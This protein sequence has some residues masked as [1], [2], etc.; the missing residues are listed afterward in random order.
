MVTSARIYGEPE[1][2][3]E[4]S[5]A[6]PSTQASFTAVNIQR[7]KCGFLSGSWFESVPELSLWQQQGRSSSGGEPCGR[8]RWWWGVAAIIG[9]GWRG[10]VLCTLSLL[11]CS[12]NIVASAAGLF[13]DIRDFTQAFLISKKRALGVLDSCTSFVG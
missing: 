9:E 1:M 5:S 2:D 13:S 10:H 12:G 8:W 3:V 6:P 7:R 4:P 11:S